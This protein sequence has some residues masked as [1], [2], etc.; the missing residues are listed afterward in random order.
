M[1]YTFSNL[2]LGD[3]FAAQYAREDVYRCFE[4][5]MKENTPIEEKASCVFAYYVINIFIHILPQEEIPPL[6]Q[7]ISYLTLEVES[8]DSID[9]IKQKIQ[10]KKGFP[11]DQQYLYFND[12]LLEDGR[13]LADYNIQKESKLCLLLRMVKEP[14]SNLKEGQY[15]ENKTIG[16]T[17]YYT[18]DGSMPSKITGIKYTEPINLIGVVGKN[19]SITIKAIATK[20]GMQKSQVSTFV[21]TISIPAA[22]YSRVNEAISR[23]NSIDKELYENY[24]K[25]EKALYQIDWNKSKQEQAIVDSY[26]DTINKAIEGLVKKNKH[27]KVTEGETFV[28]ESGKDI[29][30]KIDHEYTENVKVDD[31]EVDKVHYKVTKGSTI[32]TFDDMY[33]NTLAVGTHHVKVTFEEGIATTTLV[34]KEQTKDDNN[35]K[36]STSNNQET[37][38]PMVKAEN[39][40]E[41]KKVKTGDDE[42]I[43]GIALL[44]I[45]SLVVLT[46]IRNK[47]I[48]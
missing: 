23:V 15:E 28:K 18:M 14:I 16:A 40:Q 20:E 29:S 13:T 3:A 12:Q 31:Q 36:D 43:I 7:Y 10:D 9:N 37:V 25:V 35:R 34:I 47:K 4:K 45:G 30:I 8:G 27:Y 5:I 33:L 46:Y 32:I 11:P 1:L 2:T 38:K 41:V 19:T 39:K 48:D 42:N 26:A 22:D 17:I 24:N 6:E 44:L 21:Y